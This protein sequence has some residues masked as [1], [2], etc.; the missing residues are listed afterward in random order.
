ML[1]IAQI[2]EAAETAAAQYPVKAVK[3][4]G[5]YANGAANE[6]SDVDVLV[7]FTET[8]IS[9]C[10]LCGFQELLSELLGCRVDVVKFPLRPDGDQSFVIEKTVSLYGA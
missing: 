1:S 5:S 2:K 6:G 7:E 9:L 3:L 8:P 10:K 4:F